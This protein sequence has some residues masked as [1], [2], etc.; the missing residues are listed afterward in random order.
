MVRR[1]AVEA[2]HLAATPAATGAREALPAG[3]AGPPAPARPDAGRA[4]QALP[5][6]YASL[7]PLAA[8]IHGDL[9]LREE[10]DWGFAARATAVPLA[11][12]EFAQA[13][14]DHPIVIAPG[15]SPMPVALLGLGEGRNERVKADGRWSGGYVPAALRRHPF[16][17][18]R[19]AEGSERAVL[20]ADLAS[21]QITTRPEEGRPLF[22]EG[23]PAEALRGAL[24]FCTRYEEAM[25]R[26][27][28]LMAE[29]SALELFDEVTAMLTRPSGRARVEGFSA[30]SEE[31]L[32][33]LP[34][35]TL[36]GL[37]RR[38][39]TTLLAAHHFSMA[40]LAALGGAR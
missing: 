19:E 27:R 39:V 40:G 12:D 29:L 16:A 28:A 31:R 20:C 13:M 9:R 4:G 11:C 36:A 1:R 7:V 10:R 34:D 18:L 35:E 23:A 15:P 24:D 17:L 30:V 22:E 38:G 6:L 26:T 3:A 14:R 37:A 2:R 33:A 21:L 8:E 32:R 25:A 5:P